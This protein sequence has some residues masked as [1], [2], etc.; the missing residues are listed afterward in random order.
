MFTACAVAVGVQAEAR[1][2]RYSTIRRR[3]LGAGKFHIGLEDVPVLF[4]GSPVL[5]MRVVVGEDGE[6]E[7]D[8]EV[9]LGLSRRSPT[10]KRQQRTFAQVRKGDIQAAVDSAGLRRC[11]PGS[12]V[13]L[14]QSLRR[15][16]LCVERLYL[17]NAGRHRMT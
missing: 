15:A 2:G 7:D 4:D 9:A 8:D 13:Q 3:R 11:L 16:S 1:Q 6:T 17:V 14:T 5:G 10:A 12:A